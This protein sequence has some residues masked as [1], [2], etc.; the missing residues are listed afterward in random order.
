MVEMTDIEAVRNAFRPNTRMIWTGT[1]SNPLINRK[2]KNK[3]CR[4]KDVAA[5]GLWSRVGRM[6]IF[7]PAAAPIEAKLPAR[8]LCGSL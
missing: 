3:I 6:H 1:F 8:T 7:R 4:A 2:I 5:P